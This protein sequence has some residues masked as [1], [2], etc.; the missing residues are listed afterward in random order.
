MNSN[1]PPDPGSQVSDP[2][3]ITPQTSEEADMIPPLKR[4]VGR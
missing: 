2:W 4:G 3:T 1:Q